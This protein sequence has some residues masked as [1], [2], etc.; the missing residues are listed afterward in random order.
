VSKARVLFHAPLALAALVLLVVPGARADEAPEASSLTG[1]A[2]PRQWDPH[3]EAGR[4]AIAAAAREG[5]LDAIYLMGHLAEKGIG[6]P[7]RLDLAVR[8]Y[9][10]AARN[11]DPR[12]GFALARI[13]MQGSGGV[14][15]DLPRAVRLLADAAA[16]EHPE[17]CYALGILHDKG[18]AGVRKD[19]HRALALIRL[20][21][22]QGHR[23][24]GQWMALHEFRERAPPVAPRP[25]AAP[26][27]PGRAAGDDPASEEG[28]VT[29][30]VFNQP[31]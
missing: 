26:A 13:L 10:H 27:S 15:T 31:G 5:D 12:S 1:E 11:G 16:Q 22:S 28:P 6:Y 3:S 17:A 7:K 20:A 14:P 18:R 21:A 29:L 23:H 8:A 4:K 30:L 24:A 19:E 9:A 25:G 2:A